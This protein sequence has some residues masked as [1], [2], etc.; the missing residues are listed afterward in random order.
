MMT[1]NL[2]LKM[3]L[4]R[5]C[6]ASDIFLFSLLFFIECVKLCAFKENEGFNC[7]TSVKFC[8]LYN[9]FTKFLTSKS[10][11]IVSRVLCI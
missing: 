5:F 9:F 11:K 7:P 4:S 3:N 2:A 10:Q 6:S 8:S 1:K